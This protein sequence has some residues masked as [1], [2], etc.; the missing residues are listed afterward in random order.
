MIINGIGMSEYTKTKQNH[1]KII[2]DVHIRIS[3]CIIRKNQNFRKEFCYI[4]TNSGPGKYSYKGQEIMGSP[5][6]FLNSSI[7]FNGQVHAFFIDENYD[8]INALRKISAIGFKM[9]KYDVRCFTGKNYEILGD[10]EEARAIPRILGIVYVDPSG[11]IYADQPKNQVTYFE[12][13]SL[14]S[15]I[16]TFS[17]VD[18]LMNVSCS[19]I[20]RVRSCS[21]TK[22][23]PTLRQAIEGI[24]GKKYWLIREPYARHQWTFILGTNWYG[25]PEFEGIGLYHVRSKRGN[26][27]L[28]E[29]NLTKSEMEE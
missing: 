4:D 15:E 13:L 14:L 6:V 5:M 3:N 23:I 7:K 27:I 10:L 26:E 20:K 21:L 8:S 9:P 25:F 16:P 22:R 1:L 2:L 18:F 28:E 19:N 11:T 17:I 12:I 24:K 29:L